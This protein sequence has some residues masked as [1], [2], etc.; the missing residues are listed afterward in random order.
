MRSW[1]PLV[2]NRDEWGSLGCGGARVGQTPAYF[3]LFP[4]FPNSFNCFCRLL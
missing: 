1:Y 3:P 2:E 4:L